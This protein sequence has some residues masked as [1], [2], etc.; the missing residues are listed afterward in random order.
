[1]LFVNCSIS[2]GKSMPS[3]QIGRHADVL[4]TICWCNLHHSDLPT[5]EVERTHYCMYPAERAVPCLS[6]TGSE[7]CLLLFR[8]RV[9]E[10]KSHC[11][12]GISVQVFHLRA[13]QLA[14]PRDTVAVLI[15][16]V[17][18]RRMQCRSWYTNV[19]SSTLVKALPSWL[20]QKSDR[21]LP[22]HMKPTCF[23]AV[24]SKAKSARLKGALYLRLIPLRRFLLPYFAHPIS[25]Y[26]SP[27][28]PYCKTR[29]CLVQYKSRWFISM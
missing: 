23:H 24:R 13:Q 16:Q 8:N 17:A 1:M 5:W 21:G 14:G 2:A 18:M 26:H 20:S 28:P 3:L 11:V 25:H 29:I 12:P 6:C 10:R 15:S 7:R 4:H 22:S 19:A 27:P 9:G